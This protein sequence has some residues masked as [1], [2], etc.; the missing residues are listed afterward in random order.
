MENN[1]QN[2]TPKLVK[3]KLNLIDKFVNP[4]LSKL[5]PAK[6]VVTQGVETSPQVDSVVAQDLQKSTTPK[7]SPALL[8]KVV[9]I[10][11]ILIVLLGL[12]SVVARMIPKGGGSV[13]PTAI[14]SQTPSPTPQ[15]TIGRPS[16]YS[17]DPEIAGIKE[18]LDALDSLLNQ[19]TFREDTL[20]VPQLDWDVNFED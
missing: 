19:A 5:K 4:L 20:R 9:I 8:K 14:P 3:P 15:A 11:V 16:P 12:L 13:V 17:D 10:V 7:I 18:E 1:S 6:P 2:T